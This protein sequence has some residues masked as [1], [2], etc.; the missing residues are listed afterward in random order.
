MFVRFG[1]AT[2]EKEMSSTRRQWW[3][4]TLA[5]WPGASWSTG[6]EHLGRV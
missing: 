6:W 1:I 5:F 2:G 3:F 4:W